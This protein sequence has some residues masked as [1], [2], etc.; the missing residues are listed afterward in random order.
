MAS[1]T[2]APALAGKYP[3]TPS[4]TEPPDRFHMLETSPVS[5]SG[6]SVT[7]HEPHEQEPVPVTSTTSACEKST[8]HAV[9]PAA[10]NA[11]SVHPVDTATGHDEGH[12]SGG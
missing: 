10:L 7:V 5:Q 1:A 3:P 9:V 6:S 11:T 4:Q 8:G 2:H 12:A